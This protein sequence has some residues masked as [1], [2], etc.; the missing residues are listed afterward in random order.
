MINEKYEEKMVTKFFGEPA[1]LS[2]VLFLSTLTF[3]LA[4]QI[5]WPQTYKYFHLATLFV[6][7]LFT[8]S[9]QNEARNYRREFAINGIVASASIVTILE[10][11]FLIRLSALYLVLLMGA[12]VVTCTLLVD[13]YRLIGSDQ[14]RMLLKED[15]RKAFE[16]GPLFLRF[17]IGG[18]LAVLVFTAAYTTHAFTQ[19]LI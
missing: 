15:S 7:M 10:Y 11:L 14:V 18:I 1:R 17:L 9:Y 12:M 13:L 4:Q 3:A 5:Y 19:L 16:K 8:D 2:K 6:F